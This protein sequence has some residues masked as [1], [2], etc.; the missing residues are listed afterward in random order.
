MTG[1]QFHPDAEQELQAALD[2]YESR[3]IGLGAQLLVEVDRS[4][5]LLR[6]TP[7]LW[8]AWPGVAKRLGVRRCLLPRFPYAIAYSAHADSIVVFAVAHLSRRPGFWRG[9]V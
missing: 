5:A 3:Q 1:F 8:P 9:R 2:W 7:A 4:L 6:E